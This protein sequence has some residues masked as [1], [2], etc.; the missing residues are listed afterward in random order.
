MYSSRENLP[1][2]RQASRRH[3]GQ[4]RPPKPP[5]SDRQEA[6]C[7]PEIP[8]IVS[9]LPF[10]MCLRVDQPPFQHTAQAGS[11]WHT[12]EVTDS[13]RSQAHFLCRQAG[14]AG[15]QPM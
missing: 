4:A 11:R 1:R 13:S 9:S 8:V 10:L 5:T 6:Y 7:N 12:R 3:I 14:I 2:G 15:R